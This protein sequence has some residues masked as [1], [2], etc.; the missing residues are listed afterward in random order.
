MQKKVIK[1]LYQNESIQGG[2]IK[3]YGLSRVFKIS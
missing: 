2:F 1:G 3:K